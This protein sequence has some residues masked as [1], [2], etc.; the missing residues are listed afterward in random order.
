MNEYCSYRICGGVSDWLY[1]CFPLRSDVN[2]SGKITTLSA[3][4]LQRI[5]GFSYQ[6]DYVYPLSNDAVIAISLKDRLI[7]TYNY[8]HNTIESK[9]NYDEPDIWI[10][11]FC[12]P[13]LA[14]D[15]VES[16]KYCNKN[17]DEASIY[18]LT[19]R[20]KVLKLS[21]RSWIGTNYWISKEYSINITS[22]HRITKILPRYIDNDTRFAGVTDTFYLW[23]PSKR[24]FQEYSLFPEKGK[25]N[26]IPR[27]TNEIKLKF[28]AELV[29][30]MPTREGNDAL[31]L[32]LDNHS[33]SV[34]VADSCT[35]CIFEFSLTE[36]NSRVLVFLDGE[37][38]QC[39]G[40]RSNAEGSCGPFFPLTIRPLEYVQ[41][42]LL[43]KFSRDAKKAD[44][45]GVL[46]RMLLVFQNDQLLK[47]W[48]FPNAPEML[49][50]SGE[51]VESTLLKK[52]RGRSDNGLDS[53][54]LGNDSLRSM[55]L[56]SLGQLAVVTKDT[57]HLLFSGIS[58]K[59]AQIFN[60]EG[61]GKDS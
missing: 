30:R 43:T 51:T 24:L 34:I 58:S 50:L 26:P 25:E 28:P 36:K 56:G 17:A 54:V 45:T 31:S 48:Q 35:Q 16:E 53:V 1:D 23:L 49:D 32:Y 52:D 42:N 47:I 10:D 57:I 21:V 40:E 20:G 41:D 27:L 15:S 11:V 8:K 14:R 29:D 37:D 4:E 12:R 44:P 22:S 38:G 7:T 59:E 60:T 55:S 33:Q 3:N 19:N 39:D 46:P 13:M 5:L 61:L 6:I 9:F 18:V 2:P